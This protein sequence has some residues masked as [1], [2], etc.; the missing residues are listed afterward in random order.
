MANRRKPDKLK[1]LEGTARPGRM[2]PE[3]EYPAVESAAA[4]PPPDWLDGPEA[5]AE[6]RR[7]TELLAPTRVL[8]VADLTILGHFCNLHA[9]CVK[10]YRASLRPTAADLTQLRLYATEFGLTPASRSRAGQV[11]SDGGSA[12]GE[13]RK[14]RAG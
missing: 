3:V 11:A 10:Q 6:W 5:A 4:A 12:F 8:T 13:F 1:L 7:V 9:A 14:P 2:H